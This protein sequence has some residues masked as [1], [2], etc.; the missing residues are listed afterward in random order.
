MRDD[1]PPECIPLTYGI[2]LANAGKIEQA[3]NFF[4]N[5][6]KDLPADD[7]LVIHCYHQLGNVLDDRG[8][9]QES[10]EYFEKAL[11]K[12]LQMLPAE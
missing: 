6:L 7:S 5:V 12:K 2:V 1:I 3:E 8:K 11:A 4:R 9:Y 10:L